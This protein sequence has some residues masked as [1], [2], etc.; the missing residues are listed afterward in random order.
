MC[1]LTGMQLQGPHTPRLVWHGPVAGG[2]Y[3]LLTSRVYGRPLRAGGV[4]A[5]FFPQAQ[6]ALRAVHAAGYL[7]S[8][9]PPACLQQPAKLD[10]S[11]QH[12]CSVPFLSATCPQH[13]DAGNP[14]NLYLELQD[15]FAGDLATDS[16]ASAV[17]QV[18]AFDSICGPCPAALVQCDF[19]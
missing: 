19:I 9:C 5:E 16:T 3:A 1:P 4:D 17:Q 12:V 13:G 7:V 6:V 10:N 14:G 8:A 15:A 11:V 18:C 2:F